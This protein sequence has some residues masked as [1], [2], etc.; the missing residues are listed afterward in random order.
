MLADDSNEHKK[1]ATLSRQN[2][3]DGHLCE[4]PP[5]ERVIPY[6]DAL[7]RDAALEWLVTTDQVL[8]GLYHVYII[9]V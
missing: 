5:V 2:T 4:A 6:S 9:D 3:L 7:F 8:S 1:A